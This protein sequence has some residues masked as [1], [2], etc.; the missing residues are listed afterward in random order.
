MQWGP[1]LHKREQ[2]IH[3]AIWDCHYLKN[4]PR[5]CLIYNNFAGL[6]LPKHFWA[7]P[8]QFLQVKHIELGIRFVTFQRMPNMEFLCERYGLFEL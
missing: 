3:V 8:M 2:M 5:P 1:L 6:D 7:L 4:C